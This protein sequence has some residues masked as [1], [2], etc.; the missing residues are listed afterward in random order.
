M[1]TCHYWTCGAIPCDADG[2]LVAVGYPGPPGSQLVGE[3]YACAEHR[4]ALPSQLR[5]LFPELTLS[6]VA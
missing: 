2:E 5:R 6:E 4:E 3:F 1:N